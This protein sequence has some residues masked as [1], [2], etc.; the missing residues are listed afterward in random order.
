M[1]RHREEEE[2]VIESKFLPWEES[3]FILNDELVARSDDVESFPEKLIFPF[4]QSSIYDF[5]V[6]RRNSFTS[7]LIIISL[8]K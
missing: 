1:G 3:K 5:N 8:T 4:E 2:S 7:I 6:E